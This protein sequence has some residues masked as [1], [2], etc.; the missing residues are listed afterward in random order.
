MASCIKA[1]LFDLDGTLLP[2]DEKEFT[3]AYFAELAKRLAPFGAEPEKLV[4]SV[5]A[6]TKKMVLNDGKR[7]NEEVFWESFNADMGLDGDVLKRECDDFYVTDFHNAGRCTGKNP[8]AAAAVEAAHKKADKVILATNP[9][10]PR[11]GQITRISWVG[12]KESDFDFITSYETERYCKPNPKYFSSLLERQSL[13]AEECLVIGND[14]TE[15]M[16]AA[17]SLGIDCYLVTD[18]IIKNP[19]HPWQGKRGTFADMVR[20]INSL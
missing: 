19:E 8:L 17:S 10:F 2:M 11:A 1:I 4:A 12:L 6:G 15:D 3:K 7:T 16:L 13:K 14:E 9:L 5:W 18:C 20:Y